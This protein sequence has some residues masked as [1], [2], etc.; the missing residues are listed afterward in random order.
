MAVPDPMRLGTVCIVEVRVWGVSARKASL[1]PS[2]KR[3]VNRFL[4]TFS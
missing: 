3:G 2:G 1:L 4:W